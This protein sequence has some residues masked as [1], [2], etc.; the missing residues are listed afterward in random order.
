MRFDTSQDWGTEYVAP[1]A[2][3][4]AAPAPRM[5]VR[6]IIESMSIPRETSAQML[7]KLGSP[8]G[9]STKAK[10]ILAYVI[11]YSLKNGHAPTRQVLKMSF[12][13]L[14]DEAIDYYQGVFIGLGF[15]IAGQ[16]REV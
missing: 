6:T 3:P 5:D 11:I 2:V 13:G 8:T 16:I 12:R 1:N 14:R 9:L 4:N 10:Q 15:G 7:E